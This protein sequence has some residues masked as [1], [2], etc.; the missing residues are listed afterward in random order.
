MTA[1]IFLRFL[2]DNEKYLPKALVREIK[3]AA[4]A[5]LIERYQAGRADSILDF[6]DLA[7][8]CEKAIAGF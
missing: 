8:R 3:T 7:A 6:S 1:S 2:A 5:R 4:K